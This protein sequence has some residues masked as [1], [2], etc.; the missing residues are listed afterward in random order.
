MGRVR[1]GRL[2]ESSEVIEK[3][4]RINTKKNNQVHLTNT[5]CGHSLCLVSGMLDPFP[6]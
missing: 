5:R 4:G 6:P 2:E 3:K 1:E